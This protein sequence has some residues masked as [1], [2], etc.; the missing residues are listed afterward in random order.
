[1][2]ACYTGGGANWRQGQATVI[3]YRDYIT[4]ELGKRGGK[5]CVRGLRITVY[6]VLSYLAIGHV[7]GR[8]PG[9]L[10]GADARGRAGLP[11]LRG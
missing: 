2:T 7:D 4:I 9:G 1:M 3:D 11:C 10:P 6:D 8:D 5:P